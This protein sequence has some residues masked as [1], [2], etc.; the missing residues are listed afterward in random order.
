[1]VGCFAGKLQNTWVAHTTDTTKLLDDVMSPLSVRPL[2]N[3]VATAD[4]TEVQRN[5]GMAAYRNIFPLAYYPPRMMG[6]SKV[7]LYRKF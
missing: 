5:I 7:T 6:K 1:M 3:Q 2:G 4:F